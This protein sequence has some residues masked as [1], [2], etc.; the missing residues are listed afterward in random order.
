MHLL[1]WPTFSPD[2]SPI[3]YVWDLVGRRLAR[4]QRPAASKD[5]LSLRIEAIWN[6]LLQ[7][8]IQSLFDSMP[9]R[10]AALIAARGGYPKS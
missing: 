6:S 2:M 7:A 1:P 10:I 5:E 4:D 8:N 9:R 3:K